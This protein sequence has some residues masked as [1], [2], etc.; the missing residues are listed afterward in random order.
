MN[1]FTNN[2]R[3][4]ASVGYKNSIKSED[5]VPSSASAESKLEHGKGAHVPCMS[6]CTADGKGEGT[7]NIE[8]NVLIR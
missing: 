7:T 5:I 1:H 8:T 2:E 3:R 4:T 6:V